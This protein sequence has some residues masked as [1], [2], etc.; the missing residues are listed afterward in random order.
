MKSNGKILAGALSLAMLLG[1]A[2]LPF[3]TALCG[4][5]LPAGSNLEAIN[6]GP[7]ADH[8]LGT[9]A[10]GHDLAAQAARGALGSLSIGLAA[11]FI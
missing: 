9:D 11:A 5:N 1:L 6:L 4:F 2:S 10:L 3:L 7:G 8:C